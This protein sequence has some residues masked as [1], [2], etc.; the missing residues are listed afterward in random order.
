MKGKIMSFF[1]VIVNYKNRWIEFTVGVMAGLIFSLLGMG[2]G[3]VIV[4]SLHL[5]S[6]YPMSKAII[7]SLLLLVPISTLSA[8]LHYTFQTNIPPFLNAVFLGTVIGVITGLWIRNRISGNNLKR[9]FCIFLAIILIR[10]WLHLFD[11]NTPI[12]QIINPNYYGHFIIGFSAS[13]LSSIMGIGGG[14]LV[15][16]IYYSIL[17]F[18]A[19]IVTQTSVYVVLLNAWLNTLFSYQQL[20]WNKSLTLI[21]LGGFIGS[22]CGVY[23]FHLIPDRFL[24][25]IYGVF[26]IFILF[27]MLK[28][29]T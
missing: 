12:Q 25:I 15:V 5:F 22:I 16:T 23:M 2:P 6:N 28:N 19:K 21:A 11:L 1:H 20:Y 13:L 18:P 8:I 24:Q 10:H 17:N 4:S 7:G 27:R 26:L 14:V 9:F 29:K 3:L